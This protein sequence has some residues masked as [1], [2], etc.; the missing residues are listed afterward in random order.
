[1]SITKADLERAKKFLDDDAKAAFLDMPREE[2]LVILLSMEGSN[3][4]RL[5]VVERWQIDFKQDNRI[6]REQ[7]ERRENGGDDDMMNITQKILKAIEEADSKKF[8]FFV[9][10]RDRVLPTV[11]TAITLGILYLIFGGKL[12]TP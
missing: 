10:F 8:N 2:Q 4:N 11:M 5:A 9:W 3:S 1:M 12:P 7:R 6:Y